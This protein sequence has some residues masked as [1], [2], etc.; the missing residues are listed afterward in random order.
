MAVAVIGGSGYLGAK[1]IDGLLERGYQPEDVVNID[2]VPPKASQVEYR[3]CNILDV[4]AITTALQNISYVFHTVSKVDLSPY[5]TPA[6]YQINVDGVDNVISACVAN[7]ILGLIYTSRYNGYV[8]SKGLAETSVLKVNSETLTTVSLRSAHIFGPGDDMIKVI[9]HEAAR[10]NL[11]VAFGAGI[12]DYVYLDNCANAHLDC[13]VAVQKAP[14]KVAGQAFFLSDSP[15]PLWQHMAP[16]VHAAQLPLPS[17]LLPT[18]FMMLIAYVVEAVCFLLSVLAAISWQ[19]NVTCYTVLAI[20]QDYYFSPAKAKAAFWKT[21]LVDRQ[22]ANEATVAWIESQSWSLKETR[23]PALQ[24]LH[25]VHLMYG[26]AFC[27]LGAFGFFYPDVWSRSMGVACG[28][29]PSP[30]AVIAQ[31]AGLIIFVLGSYSVA[32]AKLQWPV[33]YFQMTYLPKLLTSA[34]YVFQIARGQIPASFLSLAAVEL[35]IGMYTYV[36]V[37]QCQPVPVK[38]FY[39]ALTAAQ[40]AHGVASGAFALLLAFAPELALP[41]LLGDAEIKPGSG[42]MIFGY[43]MGAAETTMTIVYSASGF[44]E[45]MQRFAWL[46][47]VSRYSALLTLWIGLYFNHCAIQQALGVAPDAI[48]AT[49]TLMVLRSQQAQKWKKASALEKYTQ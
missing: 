17:L 9:L 15:M 37:Q 49:F 21:P 23:S 12:Q 19:P 26:L 18:W 16:F 39:N 8:K 27:C 34:L 7:K 44:I 48:L 41:N 36:L 2:I 11:K 3:E 38:Y 20:G 45:G 28:S 25:A 46:S 13:L 14:E 33:I 30:D 32:A 47:V 42:A 35:F 1:L 40:L 43:I 10:G 24:Q 22:T 29:L 31:T 6:V 5:P 4:T